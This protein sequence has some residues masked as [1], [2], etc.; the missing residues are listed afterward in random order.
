MSSALWL[1]DV[2][3]DLSA[4]IG[5]HGAAETSRAIQQPT[6]WQSNVFADTRWNAWNLKCH[7]ARAVPSGITNRQKQRFGHVD[8]HVLVGWMIRLPHSEQIA[9][10][11]HSRIAFPSLDVINLNLFAVDEL[12]T[13]RRRRW[14]QPIANDSVVFHLVLSRTIFSIFDTVWEGAGSNRDKMI[15]RCFSHVI[16]LLTL[17]EMRLLMSNEHVPTIR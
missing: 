6:M 5:A 8:A 7:M 11:K 4:W 3:F 16:Y 13:H 17:G 9:K 10:A 2:R 14:F 15:F 12:V 1:Q